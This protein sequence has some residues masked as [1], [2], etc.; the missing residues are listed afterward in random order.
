MSA[1][2]L[3]SH[4]AIAALVAVACAAGLAAGGAFAYFSVSGHGNAVASVG[5]VSPP[6]AVSAQFIAGQVKLSWAAAKLSSGAPVQGYV[7]TRSDGA[8]VCGST[9]APVTGISCFDPTATAARNYTYTVTAVYNSFGTPA[10]TPALTIPT[11]PSLGAVS[12][13]ALGQGATGATVTIGGSGFVSGAQL[14]A[15]FSGGT[16]VTVNSVSVTSPTLLSLNLSVSR[17]ATTG[18]YALNLVN[19]DG[20]IVTLSDALV[21]DAAPTLGGAPSPSALSVGAANETVTVT[22]TGFAAGPLLGA[23]FAGGSGVTVNS[24][25]VSSA[26]TLTLNV[27]VSGSATV[28]AYA[29]NIDERRWRRGEQRKRLDG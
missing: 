28:G 8:T 5:T 23:S 17:S 3:R 20:G 9:A 14:A 15:S 18:S 1:M 21:V 6:G 7:V 4:Q 12:Q 11:A 29:L 19:G 2:R 13:P 25:T 22:G 10:V 26:T 24:V 27:S 16:G